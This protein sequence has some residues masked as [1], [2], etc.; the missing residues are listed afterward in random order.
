VTEFSR[1]FSLDTIGTTPRTVTIDASETECS[2][3][4]KRFGLVALAK[5][6]AQATLVQQGAA[7]VATGRF[8]AALTQCCIASAED[9]PALIGEGFTIRFVAALADD[10]APDEIELLA[11]DCDSVEYDGQAI[12]LGEAVAQSL[13]LAL[14][15]FPRSAAAA[16]ILRDA[17]V[18][19]EDEVVS[20]AFAGL[21]GLLQKP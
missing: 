15:P 7:I 20:G 14:D 21:K 19:S 11:D 16:R 13:G 4:C 10:S 8:D 2:A 1:A 9:V 17:G 12:D 5:L 6:T 18:L 3:L